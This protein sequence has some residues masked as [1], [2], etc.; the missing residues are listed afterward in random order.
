MQDKKGM[1]IAPLPAEGGRHR[2]EIGAVARRHIASHA[3]TF[4]GPYIHG[5]AGTEF[6]YLNWRN[7]EASPNTWIWRRKFPLAP[8]GWESARSADIAGHAFF[9]DA[10]GRKAHST[11]PAE[12]HPVA[13]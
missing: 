9:A 3:L 7:P 2:F 11:V 10:T 4:L 13:T 5:P 8:I 6:L 1:L 12:W